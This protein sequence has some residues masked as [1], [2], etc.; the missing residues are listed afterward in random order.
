[1][2]LAS[3]SALDLVA[4]GVFVL[5]FYGYGPLTAWL[6]HERTINGSLHLVRLRWMRAFLARDNR[7]PDTQLLGHIIHST[8]FFASTTM[9][10][11]A[12]MIGVISQAE[13][14]Y[15]A[16]QQLAIAAPSGLDVFELKLLALIAVLASGFMRF[17]WAIRQ[18]NYTVSL[19]GAA[20]LAEDATPADASV[21][22][23]VLEQ[24]VR[25]V[26]A[27]LR[28]FHFA[29]ALICWVA[30]PLALLAATLAVLAG[31]VWRQC[32]S[33]SSLAIRR[34]IERLKREDS[35]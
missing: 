10:L 27:G 25:S 4:L 35:A 23:A 11:I 9:L 20:P 34:H 1:M 18:L 16:V 32:S 13:R 33:P 19:M 7:I 17:S 2:M 28:T 15:Q 3:L 31:L 30:G 12:G 8:T 6:L 24:A 29:L 22:D 5:G 26:N 21:L 14:A